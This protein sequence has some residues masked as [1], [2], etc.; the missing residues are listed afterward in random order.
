MLSYTKRQ[1]AVKTLQD[2]F[3]RE[4]E[5]L[6][7]NHVAVKEVAEYYGYSIQT[8]YKLFSDLKKAGVQRNPK[9]TVEEILKTIEV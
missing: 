7:K 3:E 1:E 6:Y 8:I 9:P 5:T 4:I 2:K